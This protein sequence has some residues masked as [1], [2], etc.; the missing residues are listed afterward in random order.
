MVRSLATLLLLP[1]TLSA[2][3]QWLRLTTP[4]FEMYTTAGET[5]GR[6]AILYFEQ[7]RT[8]FQQAS[9]APQ[10]PDVPVRIIAFRGEKQYQPYRINNFATAYYAGTQD[11]EYIV[12]QDISSQHYPEAIHEYT[13]LVIRHSGLKLPLWLNEGWADLFST[14]RPMGNQARIGDLQPGRIHTLTRQ[15]W[16]PLSVLTSAGPQSPY[17]NAADQAD[18]FYAQSWALVHMLYFDPRYRANFNRFVAS[19]AIGESFP[20]ACR[21]VFAVL[22]AQLEADL[23]TYFTGRHINA[24]MVNVK[25]SKSDEEPVAA[26]LTDLDTRFVL[27]DLLVFSR[28]TEQA[29]E[30]LASLSA[31]DPARPESHESLGYLAWLNRDSNTAREHF[32][33]AIAA[34]TKDPRLCFH[35][36]MMEHSDQRVAALQRAVRLQPEYTDAWL[37]LGLALLSRRDYEGSL[38]A[39]DHVRNVKEDQASTLFSARAWAFGETGKLEEAHH[40]AD[41][42]KKWARTPNDTEQ[43]DTVH[44]YLARVE[45]H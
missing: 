1:L 38:L 12:M 42:A 45:G 36:A 29:K 9:P 7:V 35:Y 8:F 23:H 13:H 16:L 21:T 3:D 33:N 24:A 26:S 22:P 20:E 28:K 18:I 44:R 15:Q 37:Q 14:L 6:E 10:A 41:E 4:H 5:K 31:E 25:L 43:A 39:L 19:L 27:A 2:A 17:Y 30:A 34:G 40:N 11:R 32:A